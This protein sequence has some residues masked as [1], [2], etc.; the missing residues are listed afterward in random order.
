MTWKWKDGEERG[1]GEQILKAR[2]RERDG[3]E[4]MVPRRRQLTRHLQQTSG[5]ASRAC[6]RTSYR[7]PTASCTPERQPTT[8]RM[9]S[10]EDRGRTTPRSVNINTYTQALSQ[11][12]ML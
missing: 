4:V 12:G 5:R 8:D 3:Q 11:A 1:T 9:R 6:R 2:G 7:R 10:H